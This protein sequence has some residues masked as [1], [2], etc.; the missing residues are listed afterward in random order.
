[1][2][3]SKEINETDFPA[4]KKINKPLIKIS[5]NSKEIVEKNEFM[6]NVKYRPINPKYQ[7]NYY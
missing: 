1:M 7:Y 6:N 4:Y 5:E 2:K 3:K